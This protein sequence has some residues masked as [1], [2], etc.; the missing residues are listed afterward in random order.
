MLT[1]YFTD[2]YCRCIF[3][4]LTCVHGHS[5]RNTA[6]GACDR[7][8][9]RTRLRADPERGS[10]RLPGRVGASL[11]AANR[12]GSEESRSTA[13]PFRGRRAA[14]FPG[15]NEIRPGGNVEGGPNS[16]G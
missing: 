8:A 10:A 15:G 6:A 5:E 11:R 1:I 14:R 3:S 7:G 2:S 13:E 16:G 9:D 4:V 12:G